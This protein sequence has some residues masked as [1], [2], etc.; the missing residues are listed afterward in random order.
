M[1]K[2]LTAP[3][4]TA[5]LLQVLL[6]PAFAQQP[7]SGIPV[8]THEQ[9]MTCAELSKMQFNG[10]VNDAV[11]AKWELLR[12]KIGRKNDALSSPCFCREIK[13]A[14]LGFLSAK[15][16]C[17]IPIWWRSA[18]QN[19]SLTG[20]IP[21]TVWLSDDGISTSKGIRH[22][23]SIEVVRKTSSTFEIGGQAFQIE[24]S[25]PKSDK[26][27]LGKVE[28]LDAIK[29]NGGEV[30]V[31]V[32]SNRNNLIILYKQL[33]S[34]LNEIGRY[35]IKNSSNMGNTLGRHPGI[36]ESRLDAN[37]GTLTIFAVSD[38]GLCCLQRRGDAPGW[39]L[40][41]EAYCSPVHEFWRNL[42]EDSEQ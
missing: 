5:V 27:W 29:T 39:H 6:S 10:D 30:C 24:F 16:S 22:S 4:R 14:F 11:R 13:S 7:E 8:A 15:V 9:S 28:A 20:T 25:M 40:T 31:T 34:E 41:F 19:I 3:F 36:V 23:D 42:S 1:I 35:R 33:N 12:R 32:M 18:M 26:K 2:M 38:A 37:S 21:F 17:E